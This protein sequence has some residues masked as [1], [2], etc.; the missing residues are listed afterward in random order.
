MSAPGLSAHRGLLF[1]FAVLCSV[2][3]ALAGTPLYSLT[4]LGT[5]GG[6]Q[7]SANAINNL[8]AVVGSADL[9]T[10]NSFATHHAFLYTNGVITD[11]GVLGTYSSSRE[12]VDSSAGFAINSSGDIVG[13]SSTTD[14]TLHA[15]LFSQGRL[16]DLGV[17]PGSQQSNARGI[18]DSGQI[19]GWS[20]PGGI[21]HAF[22]YKNGIMSDIGTLGGTA[23]FA[24]AINNSGQIVGDS[25][26]NT[27]G[28]SDTAFIYS[29]GLMSA[30]GS[31][32]S[33]PAIQAF[34]I[35]DQGQ[36]VGCA[37]AVS[38]GGP[39]I[40][41]G[42][43][44]SGGSMVD[45]G[46]LGGLLTNVVPTA[47]NNHGQVVGTISGFEGPV[48]AF[49]YSGGVI[50]DLNSLI[51]SSAGW[52]LVHAN[53]INDSGQIVGTGQNPLLQTHAFLLTP[54]CFPQI[55]LTSS[56]SVQIE[57]TA[58]AGAGSEIEYQDSISG[59]NWLSLAVLDPVTFIH[60]VILTDPLSTT[61]P[62]R[63][64]RIIPR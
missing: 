51:P 54:G 52:T 8:G 38:T 45:L 18:N 15:F 28:L 17:L 29:N 34:A 42:F 14:G 43:L 25:W 39:T 4:D 30:L 47:I 53:G 5:L 26:L 56:N 7:S 41:R 49:V 16:V 19:V 12:T 40:T 1:S 63:F 57:F 11:L 27:S 50:T 20:I 37:G 46:D 36:L 2:L 44:S 48:R 32:G 3:P 35:N 9:A 23:S 10:T 21:Q 33:Q 13:Q 59:T 58:Q 60:Q 24:Y 62:T 61:S 22:L 31:L 6:A 64:Y 55:L